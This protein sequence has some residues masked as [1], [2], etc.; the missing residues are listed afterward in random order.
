MNDEAARQ[1][2]PP[3]HS[4]RAQTLHQAPALIVRLP[5]EQPGQILLDA[6]SYEDELRLR[7][8]LRRSSAMRALPGILGRLLDDL[9]A[10]EGATA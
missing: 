7:A 8:W 5:L 9:D 1:G 6:A 3:T 4:I 10:R 2:G